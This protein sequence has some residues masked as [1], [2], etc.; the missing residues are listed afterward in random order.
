[1]NWHSLRELER[2]SSPALGHQCSWSSSSYFL[3][4]A[5]GPSLDSEFAVRLFSLA[6]QYVLREPAAA[7]SQENWSERRVLRP[8]P[9]PA[10]SESPFLKRWSLSTLRC[11]KCCLQGP[12]F[13]GLARVICRL[14][15]TSLLS[16]RSRCLGCAPWFCN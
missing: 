3:R 10:E 1:M 15:H 2:P 9:R 13:I 4:P 8:H 5:S 12:R 16:K 11:E 6:V 14:T 7:A